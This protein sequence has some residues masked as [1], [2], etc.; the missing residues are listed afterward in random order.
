MTHPDIKVEV[1][2]V[3][4]LEAE[5]RRRESEIQ[6]LQAENRALSASLKYE[7]NLRLSVEKNLAAVEEQLYGERQHK[8]KRRTKVEMEEFRNSRGEYSE[9]KSN[10][11]KKAT[12]AETIRS[13][14]DYQKMYEALRVKNPR[15]ALM[16]TFG[17]CFGIRVSDIC[18]LKWTY[19]L[20]DSY[21]FRERL[22]IREQKT[23][24][25]QDCLITEAI[26]T[27]TTKYL[28]SI[29]WKI[30]LQDPIFLNPTTGKSVSE[31]QF[32]KIIVDAK[33]RA[34][35]DYHIS[36]HSMRNTFANIVLCVD[37]SSI[38]MNALTKVQALLNHSDVKC[39][40]RYLG[41]L[42]DML[43]KARNTVS[44]F[45]LGKTGVDVLTAG[46]NGTEDVMRKLEE[47]E[48]MMK[49]GV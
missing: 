5:I 47:L 32:Y 28:N 26:R 29:Q 46:T 12:K 8:R 3:A 17:V 30:N 43:D 25:I 6:A 38:N 36:T 27:E 19:L 1:D 18:N 22:K 42:K 44:D 37:K 10:G 11:V 13:Y 15:D 45:V 41:S 20:D 24:K 7:K 34:G 49:G 48:Q 33:K 23:S 2:Q 9:Q 35:I 31:K 14:T 16:W 39:T 40:M 21:Q 4:L